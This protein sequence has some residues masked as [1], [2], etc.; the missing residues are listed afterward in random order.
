MRTRRNR[1]HNAVLARVILSASISLFLFL[2]L[3][4]LVQ[5]PRRRIAHPEYPFV[6]RYNPNAKWNRLTYGDLAGMTGKPEHKILRTVR[7]ETDNYGFMNSG[8]SSSTPQTF[9]FIALGDSFTAASPIDQELLWPNQLSKITGC[10]SYNL[11]HPAEG[12]W[13][14]LMNFQI[15][16]DR[17]HLSP[18]ARVIWALFSGN[19]L[20][21]EYGQDV[22]L[23]PPQELTFPGKLGR[24]FRLRWEHNPAIQLLELHK[25]R[26][27]S[28]NRVIERHLPD[29][30]FVLFLK[31][32]AMRAKRDEAELLQHPNYPLFVATIEEMKQQCDRRNLILNIVCFPSKEEVYSWLCDGDTPWSQPV[33]SSA[34]SGI[35]KRICER[36]QIEFL[37][38][39]EILIKESGDLY[40]NQGEL[41]YWQ[42]DTHFNKIGHQR[43][44]EYMAE[45]FYGKEEGLRQNKNG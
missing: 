14:S 45:K 28:I 12:P 5:E 23:P 35:L 1:S 36:L 25:K 24:F 37:D 17:L 44:A 20:D 10:K 34:F 21:G 27:Q 39:T 3:I 13:H 4:V 19:D 26:K 11:G 30:R 29:G 9:D 2:C 41:F 8:E 7:Q 38:L 22:V 32:Y 16:I 31:A 15:E 43:T 6:H 42:D 40:L 33:Q 18:E